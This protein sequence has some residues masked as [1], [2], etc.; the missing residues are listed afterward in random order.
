VNA[1]VALNLRFYNFTRPHKSLRDPYTRTPAMAA[2]VEDH[3]WTLT[4]I[5]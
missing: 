3:I 4:D 5:A 2:G 1:A